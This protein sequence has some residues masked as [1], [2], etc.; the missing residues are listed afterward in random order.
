MDKFIISLTKSL[1][2]LDVGA[3]DHCI[4]PFPGSDFR[5]TFE[6]ELTYGLPASLR[7]NF[8]YKRLWERNQYLPKKYENLVEIDVTTVISESGIPTCQLFLI[9]SGKTNDSET[10]G[11]FAVTILSCRFAKVVR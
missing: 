4:V 3:T 11:E 1:T 7:I 9:L 2:D 10:G 5:G 8:A 6:Q